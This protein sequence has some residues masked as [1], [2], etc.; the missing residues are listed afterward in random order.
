M[1][2]LLGVG[3]FITAHINEELAW[4]D[5]ALHPSEV[6]YV[7]AVRDA[8]LKLPTE[9]PEEIQNL[10][11]FIV[12][13][14]NVKLDEEL[15]HEITLDD[16]FL[17]LSWLSFGMHLAHPS[18]F[19][20]YGFDGMYHFVP[21]IAETFGIPLQPVPAKKDHLA[22]WLYFGQLCLALQEFRAL[23]GMNIPELLAFM[24]DFS[25]SFIDS[26][27]SDDLP[28]PR[29]AWL[30]LGGGA[31]DGD[32]GWLQEAAP[33]AQS[34]WQG[35]LE[36]RRGDVCIMYVRSPI[37]SIHSLWRAIEDGYEDPFFHY[38]HAVQIGQ[39]QRLP[40]LHFQD[41]ANDIV[42]SENKYVKANLQGA[43]GKA[44]TY[45]EYE[46]L[47]K[48]L[49]LR[50]EISS[51]LPHFPEQEEVE[52]TALANERDVEIRLIEPLL[53]RAGLEAADW[54]RQL[55]VRVG[56]G[57]R[58]YPDYAIGVTGKAPELRVRAL[59]EAKYR[60]AG[61]KD[62]REAFFQAKAYG[63]RLGARVIITAAA[64]GLRLY[65]RRHDDFDFLQGQQYRWSELK[66]GE[67]LR[68]L[69]QLLRK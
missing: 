1:Q 2:P 62:W 67:N 39:P 10:M 37:S 58:V 53:Q 4:E 9:T 50:G 16:P 26:E 42:F 46:H 12:Q 47:L 28:A 41:L 55:P 63:M 33:D 6:A 32:Y 20:P 27:N 8:A 45:S 69:S 56:R 13:P 14:G 35:N 24:Y 64:E 3:N 40:N 57:E 38:K 30:L 52:L 11:S 7:L 31:K 17:N 59:V 15:G 68:Q 22:R 25:I 44:L 61:E 54:V 51:N 49:A 21:K 43:S 65:K 29:N 66:E 36:M 48:I 23:Q 5:T 19:L 60:A 18:I 34:H